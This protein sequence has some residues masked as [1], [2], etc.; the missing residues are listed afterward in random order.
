MNL[1]RSINIFKRNQNI[2]RSQF[3]L[4]TGLGING[5]NVII[6]PKKAY[7]LPLVFECI[8]AICRTLMLVSP[9]VIENTSNGKQIASNHRVHKLVNVEPY[10]L[11]DSSKYFSMMTVNYLLFGNAYAEITPKGLKILQPDLVEPYILNENGT[12]SHWYTIS[13]GKTKRIVDQSKMIHIYDFSLDGIKGL[14][15]IMMKKD[16]LTEVSNIVNYSSDIYKSGT[17][18][19]GIIKA[20]K[21][22]EK[23]AF[24]YLRGKFEEQLSGKNGGIASL[25]MDYEYEPL[26]YSLP[27]ADA[28]IIEAK[29]FTVEEVARIFGVP[30]S[31]LG[32]GE[33]AD[34]KAQS[35]YNT[36]LSTVIAPLTIILE[37]EHNRKLFTTAEKGR[38]YIKFELKGLY[39]ADMLAR[40][41]AHQIALN[42][43]FMCKDEVR[44]VEGMNPVPDGLGKTFYQMLNTIPLDQA[45]AYYKNLIENNQTKMN[46]NDTTGN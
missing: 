10:T 15:R 32:R 16:T 18:V 41:Q 24:E 30:M 5:K 27:F 4:M 28:Q 6:S 19:S 23:N 38:F 7:T 20:K 44:E 43:G 33:S 31:L 12:E 35:E 14:S 13:D 9:K 37:N 21:T 40:Y 26:Q 3:Q 46:Q 42:Q 8:D 1:F 34:N 45:E 2:D 29:K 39:R 17:S 22:I 25:T 11:Y 36:F